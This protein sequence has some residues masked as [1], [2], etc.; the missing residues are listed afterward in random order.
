MIKGSGRTGLL[1]GAG[2]TPCRLAAGVGVVA[3]P[4]RLNDDEKGVVRAG[5]RVALSVSGGFVATFSE[6]SVCTA[7]TAAGT[8]AVPC[9]EVCRP[10]DSPPSLR[11]R[12]EG[13]DNKSRDVSLPLRRASFSL[14]SKVRPR[15]PPASRPL[16]PSSLL[17]NATRVPRGVPSV[18]RSAGSWGDSRTSLPG[19]QEERV[20]GVRLGTTESLVWTSIHQ[21]LP[22]GA[23]NKGN[24]CS[25]SPP[26][27]VLSFPTHSYSLEGL[28][29]SGKNYAKQVQGYESLCRR[30]ATWRLQS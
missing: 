4:S 19:L 22:S 12:S 3:A 28:Y 10:G 7:L 27:Y 14:S 24:G 9:R 23:R 20:N 13:E 17:R 6:V 18:K 2:E 16:S 30:L 25:W 1:G 21:M 5:D 29:P 11:L 15:T 26:R 8:S